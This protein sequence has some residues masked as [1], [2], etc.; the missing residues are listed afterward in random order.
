MGVVMDIMNYVY[1]VAVA[2]VV[3]GVVWRIPLPNR[4]WGNANQLFSREDE[5]L[6]LL[7]SKD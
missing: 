3:I 4:S 5:R 2:I 1:V 6:T 7:G